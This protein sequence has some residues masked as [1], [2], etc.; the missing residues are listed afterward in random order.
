MGSCELFSASSFVRLEMR[1]WSIA[2]SKLLG[3]ACQRAPSLLQPRCKWL[4]PSKP[5]WIC[6]AEHLGCWSQ[7]TG[8]YSVPSL[9]SGEA[10][11]GGCWPVARRAQQ[12]DI[13]TETYIHYSFFFRPLTGW[14]D[15]LGASRGPWVM[16]VCSA[17]KH[18][19]SFT[20][21]WGCGSP[22]ELKFTNEGW[23]SKCLSVEKTTL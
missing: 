7:V 4:F 21:K 17:Q 9:L 14:R 19:E 13:Y 6:L 22:N 20:S 10:E 18:S 8:L 23:D 2:W 15:E 5:T 11:Q 1:V 3:L 16:L 12:S